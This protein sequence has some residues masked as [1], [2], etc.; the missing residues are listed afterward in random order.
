MVGTKIADLVRTYLKNKPYTMEALESGIVNFSSLS[1]LIQKELSIKSYQAV[2]AAVRRHA[3][4]IG[5]IKN[6]IEK[7]A[8]DVLKENRIT[9]L[10][11]IYV[12]ISDKRLEIENKA[13]V[14][15]DSYYV[16]LTD[17]SAFKSM[18]RKQKESLIKVHENCSA[19]IIYSEEKLENVSGVLAFVTSLLAERNINVIEFI[20]CY[21]ETMLIVSKE[22]ALRSYE[23]LSEIIR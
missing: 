7:R 15:V 11:G 21:T 14:K 8:L 10:D 18:T 9:L 3:E 13:E 20:S 22:D 12:A 2:K 23:A 19:I 17:K 5:S 16:Y 4:H 6:T 1:R